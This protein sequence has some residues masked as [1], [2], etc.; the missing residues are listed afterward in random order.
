MVEAGVDAILIS[1]VDC[2]EAGCPEDIDDNGQVDVVDLLAVIAAW[3]TSDPNAD[4]DGNGSVDVSDLLAVI[5]AWGGCWP[6]VRS[7]RLSGRSL[8]G[9]AGS[10]WPSS[11]L[12]QS[13][14]CPASLESD[15]NGH[16]TQ[17][18]SQQDS[19]GCCYGG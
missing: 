17:G 9:P 1:T 14:Q 15:W 5:A 4:L 13:L 18:T 3:G 19:P 11:L 8:R 12:L 10:L 16:D 6:N 7:R 2:D